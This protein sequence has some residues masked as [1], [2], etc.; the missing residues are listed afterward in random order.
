MV[1]KPMPKENSPPRKRIYWLVLLIF[2]LIAAIWFR[3]NFTWPVGLSH[4]SIIYLNGAKGLL[5]G[6]GYSIT[7][8]PPLYPAA[9]AFIAWLSGAEIL[10]AATALAICLFG[11]NTF[12]LGLLAWQVTDSLLSGL[13]IAAVFILLPG[14]L[15]I[16]FEAM[17]EP[18]FFALLLSTLLFLTAYL[19]SGKLKWAVLAG[20][21][22]GLCILA[23]Y[24]GV[25][26]IVGAVVIVFFFR[27][28]PLKTRL[29]HSLV[30]AV[31]GFT[32]TLPWLLNNLVASGEMTNRVF[33]YHPKDLG[34]F[35]YGLTG[36]MELAGIRSIGEGFPVIPGVIFKAL[37]VLIA[38]LA[39]YF[40]LVQ[41]RKGFPRSL[42]RDFALACLILI[43]LYAVLLMFSVFFYDASTRLTTR[44]LSPFLLLGLA[45]G[46]ALLWPRLWPRQKTSRKRVN[47]LLFSVFVVLLL[48]VNFSGMLAVTRDFRQNGFLFSGKAWQTSETV[49][50][51]KQLPEST[52]LYSN[53][54]M[55]LGFLT[56]QPV[57]SIPER[58]NLLQDQPVDFRNQTMEMMGDLW[59]GD[60]ML[61]IITSKSYEWVYPPKQ[62]VVSTLV[63]CQKFP[64]GEIFT[65]PEYFLDQCDPQQIKESNR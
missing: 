29:L 37:I 36:L 60:A 11:L 35:R 53:E 50:W 32:F 10:S 12:L 26:V 18:L 52:L 8:F 20:A 21:S 14:M 65:A 45:A 49:A 15:Q 17:S 48:A 24:V 30:T 63:V 23:R 47:L 25:F 6:Q 55:P 5:S 2:S 46:W 31:V 59:R 39:L 58:R 22:G 42:L 4:D 62:Q 27:Q 16:H 51:L 64:D 7:H 40:L 34:Y 43:G 57:K 41:Y 19:R 56:D 54:F 61:V 1:K 9:V 38:G 28:R 33:T 44:I 13:G 3:T